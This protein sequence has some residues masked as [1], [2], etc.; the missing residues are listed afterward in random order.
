MSST[1]EIGYNVNAANLQKMIQL[2]QSFGAAY[3]PAQTYISISNMENM[4]ADVMASLNDLRNAQMQLIHVTN[5]RI[6]AYALL[7]PAATSII[8]ALDA[9]NVP[10]DIILDARTILRKIR[11]Y[12]ESAPISTNDNNSDTNTTT[13]ST[14]RQSYNSMLENF[15]NLIALLPTQINYNPNEDNL[16]ITNLQNYTAQLHTANN[17]VN[18][19]LFAVE[20]AR[21]H[22]NAL[23][24]MPLTG[25]VDTALDV[26]K[27]IKSVFGAASQQYKNAA[28]ITFTRYKYTPSNTDFLPSQPE[29]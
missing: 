12:K 19:Q 9:S 23:Q 16:K 17:L 27:Y 29:E 15:N 7:K 6:A 2:C 18:T 8:N 21:H 25:L 20:N 11:N 14:S 10:N 3:N 28:A 22:R 13:I 1:S 26:K 5:Q 24:L 4:Y